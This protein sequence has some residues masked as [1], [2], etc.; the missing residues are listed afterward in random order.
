MGLH[1]LITNIELWSRTGTPLYVRDLVLELQRQGHLPAAYTLEKGPIAR[2]LVAA[3][4]PL[5]DCLR[6]LHVQPEIIHGHHCAT[7]LSAVQYYPGV[8]AIFICHDY[9]SP[10]DRTPFHPRI[11]RYFG[12]SRVCVERLIRDGVPADNARLLLNFVDTK[13]FLPRPPLPERARQAL[14]FSNNATPETYLPALSEACRRVGLELDVVGAGVGRLVAQPESILGQYDIVFAKGKAA[15]EA[16]A[17]G[18]A[19]ILCDYSGMGPMVTSA[20]FDE[21]RPLNFGSQTL[22]A[23]LRP[24]NILHQIARYDPQD[25][26]RVRDLLRASASLEQATKHLVDIYREVIE[27]CKSVSPDRS[28]RQIRP[29]LLRKRLAMKLFGAWG[30]LQPSQRATLRKLPGF[31]RV[32]DRVKRMLI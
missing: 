18:T 21:L 28:E 7:T 8:P 2:E 23:P 32:K 20:E 17:V 12:V 25:A 19:V 13:R 27:E 1:V 10:N 24:E 5:T 4:I 30:V 22:R 26:A 14:V 31:G 9:T 16:M 6:R 29:W 15:M 3:G 11:R